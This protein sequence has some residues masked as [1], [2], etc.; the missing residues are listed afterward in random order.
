[1]DLEKLKQK[2]S[3]YSSEKIIITYH[4]EIQAIFREIDLEEVKENIRNPEKLVYVEEQESQNPEENKY[5]CY[6]AYSKDFAHRYIF[7]T[8]GN[9]II[10]TVIKINKS[11][12]KTI[13][14][15]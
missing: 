4:A 13:K 12:Q 5:N 7:T 10:V 14:K 11:W 6:F 2:I 8:N 1:M 3:S 15:K 9:L